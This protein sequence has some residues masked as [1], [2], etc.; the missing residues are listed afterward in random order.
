MIYNNARYE[1]RYWNY[2]KYYMY[3]YKCTK[4]SIPLFYLNV[5]HNTIMCLGL[6][7]IYAMLT[8]KDCVTLTKS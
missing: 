8:N 4:S 5:N 6:Q 7:E 3:K 2:M 1:Y